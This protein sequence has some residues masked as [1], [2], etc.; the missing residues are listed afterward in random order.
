MRERILPPEEW[1]RLDGTEAE[2]LW[3]LLDP[4]NAKVIA[5]EKDG[6]LV[7]CWVA[8]RTVHAECVWI[9]PSHRGV[10]GV[11]MR[12]LKGMGRVAQEWGTNKVITGSVTPHVTD[13]IRRL[14]GVPLP[15]ESFVLPVGQE[16]RKEELC[17]P[18]LP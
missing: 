1:H 4:D 9:K 3:P 13:L 2:S 16:S 15:C 14:G 10:F 12:L 8:M 7:G 18:S 17:L 5:V 11:A 6:E